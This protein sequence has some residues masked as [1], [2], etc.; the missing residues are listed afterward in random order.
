M[1]YLAHAFLSPD[2][3]EQLM[4]NLWGDLLKPR[5]YE[6]LFSVNFS[7]EYLLNVYKHREVQLG[8]TALREGRA[9]AFKSRQDID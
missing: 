8:A 1:N 9:I 3:P 2:D 6:F 5:D 4:G 7:R